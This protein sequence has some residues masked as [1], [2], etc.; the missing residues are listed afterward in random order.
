M[1][2]GTEL[3]GYVFLLS[4]GIFSLGMGVVTAKFGSGDSRNIG[5]I[6]AVIGVVALGIFFYLQEEAVDIVVFFLSSGF[7][8]FLGACAGLGIFLA[9][10]MKS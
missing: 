10:I 3:L 8:A 4:F 1:I 6:S 7:G 2:G 5:I 9:S